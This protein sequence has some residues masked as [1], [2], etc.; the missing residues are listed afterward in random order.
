MRKSGQRA[1]W[2]LM[3]CGLAASG[4]LCNNVYRTPDRLI[5]KPEKQVANLDQNDE[6]RVFVQNNYHVYVNNLSL[7]A[8]LDGGGVDVKVTPERMRPI[9]AGE[10]VSFMV[11]LTA[12]PGAVKGERALKFGLTADN[13]GYRPLKEYSADDMYKVTLDGNQSPGIM[14]AESLIKLKDPRGLPTLQRMA[15]KLNPDWRGR[16][17]RALGKAGDPQ[18]IPFLQ[19]QLTERDGWLKGNALLAL[20]LL[21][22]KAD[23]LKPFVDDRDPFVKASALAALVLAGDKSDAL[24]AQLK[25][26][27]ASDNAYVR[28]ASAWALGT[29]KDEESIK[30]AAD[31]L[32]K[33]FKPGNPQ[34]RVCAG[35]ALVDLASRLSPDGK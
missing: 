19:E 3:L 7:R 11:K 22:D 27:L 13:I 25:E 20:G 1:L 16:A 34:Q 8:D 28:I 9:K 14:A 23:T 21:K 18:A 17:L 35:D 31:S 15:K 6:F 2:V 5:V 30:A 33:D 29:F 32:D 24:K 4:H 12:Q 26:G 10:R